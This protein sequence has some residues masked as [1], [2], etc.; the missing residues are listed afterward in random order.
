MINQN[1]NLFN[2]PVLGHPQGLFILF[3]TEMWERFSYY[4]MRALLVLFLIS[5]L[6]NGGWN[7]SFVNASALYSTYIALVYLTPI[8]GGYLADN[9]LGS[10]KAVI[11]GTIIMTLGHASMALEFNHIFL[12]IGISCLIIVN[13]FFKPN[14]TSII[15]KMYQNFP[16]KKDG[17][18]TIFYMGVNAGS[19]LGIMLCGYLGESLGW[20][21]GF[22]CLNFIFLK[23]YSVILD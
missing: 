15:S 8:L 3:F 21:Y 13:V 20:S 19:F 18:F 16:E 23:K 12:Y 2:L 17:A 5:S 6:G 10:R 14:I 4:G 11:I 1:N 22:E 7:W 9:F